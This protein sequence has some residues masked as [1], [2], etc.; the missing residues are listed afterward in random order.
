MIKSSSLVHFTKHALHHGF[1]K[2]ERSA[3]AG[4]VIHP[5]ILLWCQEGYWKRFLLRTDWQGEKT[6][7]LPVFWMLLG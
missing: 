7:I 4:V 2:L 1:C 6:F 3:Y 5:S